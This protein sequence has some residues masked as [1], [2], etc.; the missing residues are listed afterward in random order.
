MEASFTQDFV[1]AGRSQRR[2]R[3]SVVAHARSTRKRLEL[4]GRPY[5]QWRTIQTSCDEFGK[6]D[7]EEVKDDGDNERTDWGSRPRVRQ[8][9]PSSS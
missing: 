6:A 7:I 9:F 2:A 4:R 3:S 8:H 5:P 1:A